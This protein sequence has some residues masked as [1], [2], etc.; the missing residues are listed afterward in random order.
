MINSDLA[1]DMLQGLEDGAFLV[2]WSI[3]Q[4][5]KFAVSYRQHGKYVKSLIHTHG[6][7]GCSFEVTPLP[8]D[9]APTIPALIAM[10]P[11]LFKASALDILQERG[12]EGD[13]DAMG[14][15]GTAINR[16]VTSAGL[17]PSSS[18]SLAG[19]DS[20]GSMSSI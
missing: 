8:T 19:G 14:V 6:E 11:D 10:R 15:I 7:R 13:I 5:G 4:T 18:R 1:E 17:S 9:L 16:G 20:R 3:G 12:S 2:R